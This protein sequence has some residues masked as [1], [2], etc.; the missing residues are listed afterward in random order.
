MD[1][2]VGFL[3]FVTFSRCQKYTRSLENWLH[4]LKNGSKLNSSRC[5]RWSIIQGRK[6]I[7]YTNFFFNNI[8]NISNN[9]VFRKI[10]FYLYIVLND[11]DI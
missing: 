3:V 9:C 4:R 7:M 10:E 2:G 8:S 6:V 1:C 11:D 5:I